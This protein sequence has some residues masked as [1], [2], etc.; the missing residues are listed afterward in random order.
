M[1]KNNQIHLPLVSIVIPCFNDG[2]Y[3]DETLQSISSQ[4]YPKLETI[5]INDGSTDKVTNETLKNVSW[6]MTV[7]INIEHGG[8]AAAR[9][10]GINIANGK[11]ILALDADDKIHPSYV[12]KAVNVLESNRDVGIV[13]CLADYFGEAK[14]RWDLP[15]YSFERMLLDNIIFATALF[16]KEDWQTVGGYDE[17]LIHGM[18]D[19]DFW[20]SL[21]EMGRNVVQ[22]PEVLFYYRIREGSRSRRL[23]SDKN[24]LQETYQ[25]IYRN[26]PKL[27][28]EYQELYVTVLRNALIDQIFWRQSYDILVRHRFIKNSIRTFLLLNNNLR[29][30]INKFLGRRSPD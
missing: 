6:P 7:I 14:G 16:R 15:A 17:S 1:Q 8:P 3:L 11:Y 20:L 29:A 18:E 12:S 19:Y 27:Y 30:F 28:L 26:H 25:K 9:N 21:I 2:K 4:D 13:Y 24:Q 23:V 10:S 5:I 22:L